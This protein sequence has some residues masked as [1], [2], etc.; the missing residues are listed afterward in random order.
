MS[1]EQKTLLILLLCRQKNGNIY[2]LPGAPRA[3][4]AIAPLTLPDESEACAFQR[5]VMQ[6]GLAQMVLICDALKTGPLDSLLQRLPET[7]IAV[8]DI[9]CANGEK[10]KILHALCDQITLPHTLR[11]GLRIR[12]ED[13]YATSVPDAYLGSVRITGEAQK[14]EFAQELCDFYQIRIK[15]ITNDKQN[16]KQS[17][18]LP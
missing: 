4:E 12:H 13:G 15:N 3:A 7:H 18:S 17:A 9:A 5:L 11:D 14:S 6:D 10:G 1:R 16:E 2:D 8:R